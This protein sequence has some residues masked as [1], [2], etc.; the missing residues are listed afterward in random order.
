MTSI[1]TGIALIVV[2]IVVD[3]WLLASGR[4]TW[5]E[6]LYI[7]GT[8]KPLFPYVWGFLAGHWWPVGAGPVIEDTFGWIFV[9]VWILVALSGLHIAVKFPPYAVLIPAY[10]AGALLWPVR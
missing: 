1:I 2:A 3:V 4:E 9:A 10:F 6:L 5:S 7:A 8:R